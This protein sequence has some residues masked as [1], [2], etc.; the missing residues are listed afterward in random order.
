MKRHYEIMRIMRSK[1]PDS[2]EMYDSAASIR[3]VYDAVSYRVDDLTSTFC[4]FSSSAW[5][6]YLID[7]LRHIFSSKA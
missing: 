3:C 4:L 1:I 2:R 7:V 6:A 5:Y